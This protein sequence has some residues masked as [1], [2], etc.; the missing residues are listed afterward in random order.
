MP[1]WRGPPQVHF[2]S[3]T[4]TGD[5]PSIVC[6]EPLVPVGVRAEAGWLALP[7]AGASTFRSSASWWAWLPPLAGA[8]ISLFAVST[9]DTDD[10]LV[11]DHDLIRA[12]EVLRGNGDLV[13]EHGRKERLLS[14]PDE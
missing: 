6:S 4:R 3:I 12:I 11:K 14:G 9:F 2:F 13:Q 5:E 1:S 10:L 7:V 8:G